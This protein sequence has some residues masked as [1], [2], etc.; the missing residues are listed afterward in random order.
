ML[1]R[2]WSL[3]WPLRFAR[4]EGGDEGGADGSDTGSGSDGA[5][6]SD[7]EDHGDTGSDTGAAEGSDDAGKDWKA[8]YEKAQAERAAE[9]QR[10]A[11]FEAAEKQRADEKK[12]AEERAKDEAA[13]EKAKTAAA[14][15]RVVSMAVS[16]EF[17]KRHPKREGLLDVVKLPEACYEVDESD[18]PKLTAAARKALDSFVKGNPEL[19]DDPGDRTN[20]PGSG[21]NRSG[22][23]NKATGGWFGQ[24]RRMTGQQ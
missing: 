21:G 18:P 12:T 19:F 9:R 13:A 2:H 17:E 11:A 7:A 14:N 15:K 1:T 4:F 20:V 6:G 16:L 23:K 10:L 24:L 22:G 3:P 5:E 8:E